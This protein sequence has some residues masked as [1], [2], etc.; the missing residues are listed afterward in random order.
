MCATTANPVVCFCLATDVDDLFDALLGDRVE[1]GDRAVEGLAELEVFLL[2]A[3][4]VHIV[5]RVVVWLK[6]IEGLVFLCQGSCPGV[7]EREH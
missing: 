1:A 4:H 7:D 6:M 3:V 2:C 5:D